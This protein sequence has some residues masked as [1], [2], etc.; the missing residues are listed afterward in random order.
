MEQEL[1]RIPAPVRSQIHMSPA[2]ATSIDESSAFALQ[3]RR[4]ARR[5]ATQALPFAMVPNP[6]AIFDLVGSAMQKVQAEVVLES[7]LHV[8]SKHIAECQY[9]FGLE[10]LPTA[11]VLREEEGTTSSLVRLLHQGSGEIDKSLAVCL[12]TPDEEDN[13]N[14]RNFLTRTIALR[15]QMEI[16]EAAD[17]LNARYYDL[18]TRIRR[19]RRQER[20]L[21]QKLSGTVGPGSD[22]A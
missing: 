12:A 1:N 14:R 8:S 11:P 5:V 16:E 15:G 17:K 19:Q 21:Y 13:S 18:I 3:S 4:P 20:K 9:K 7:S 22:A 6:D 10:H 2:V